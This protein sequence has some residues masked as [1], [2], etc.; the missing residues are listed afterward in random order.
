MNIDITEGA[1]YT[2][3]EKVFTVLKK[4][5]GR[6]ILLPKDI[7]TG[8]ECPPLVLG[9]N[10]INFFRK[11]KEFDASAFDEDLKKQRIKALEK[12][13]KCL[14]GDLSHNND[15]L[16]RITIEIKAKEQDIVDMEKVHKDLITPQ[17]VKFIIG[18]EI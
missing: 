8:Q 16:S 9:E 15:Q 14:K 7:Y 11:L 2:N 13:I 6:Y 12:R 4:Y 18:D 1:S 3:D 10:D 5:G 17:S